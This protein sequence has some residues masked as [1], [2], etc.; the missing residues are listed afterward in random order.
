[1]CLIIWVNA[2]QFE[3]EKTRIRQKYDWLISGLKCRKWFQRAQKP[4]P[5]TPKPQ[6]GPPSSL[7]QQLQ[8]SNLPSYQDTFVQVQEGD[9]GPQT[10]YDCEK[11]GEHLS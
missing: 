1:M 9:L 6:T 4:H 5:Q 8:P 10:P 2:D 11:I 7:S 3:I